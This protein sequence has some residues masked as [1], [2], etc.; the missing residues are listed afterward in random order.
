MKT[1]DRKGSTFFDSHQDHALAPKEHL[2]RVKV[3]G[4]KKDNAMG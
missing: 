1:L 3:P 4:A 2:T